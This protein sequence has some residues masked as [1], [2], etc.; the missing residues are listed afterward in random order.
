VV[1]EA[2][3][4]TGTVVLD[5]PDTIPMGTAGM[6]YLEVYNGPNTPALTRTLPLSIACPTNFFY[7]Q[8]ADCV[9]SEAVTTDAAFQRF[10]HGM[11]V[12]RADTKAMYALFDDGTARRLSDNWDG[13]PLSY[14][15]AQPDGLFLPTNG[16][17]YAWL[18]DSN[19]WAMLGYA[20]AP[21]QAYNGE[22]Q[23][24][25]IDYTH[26]LPPDITYFRLADGGVVRFEIT[27]MLANWHKV[28]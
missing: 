12:W 8:S 9:L 28:M 24:A 27:G 11:M 5:I 20:T 6:I 25:S 14:D 23:Q 18:N 26:T 19:L 1:A 7:G 2:L 21:E 4:L 22:F 10:E 13:T 3:P 16:F 17:G 15:E